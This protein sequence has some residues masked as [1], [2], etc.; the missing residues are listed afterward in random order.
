[1]SARRKKKKNLSSDRGRDRQPEFPT[2]SV[3][4]EKEKCVY[5]KGTFTRCWAETDT[6]RF[7]IYCKSI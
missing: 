2:V 7:C 6:T 3:K 4:T 5:E 1:M